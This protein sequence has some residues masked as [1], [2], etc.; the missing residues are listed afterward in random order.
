L[1][2]KE[3]PYLVIGD[4]EVPPGATVVIEPGTIF[5]FKNFTTLHIHGTLLS[6]G[7]K[8]Q[9]IVFSSENDTAYN[10]HSSLTP[11]AYDWNGITV[12]DNSNGT[13]FRHCNIK[14]SLYGIN[15]LTKSI[16]VETCSFIQIGKV[17]LT[18]EGSKYENLTSDFVFNASVPDTSTKPLL[19][20]TQKSEPAPA[21]KPVVPAA[22]PR[23]SNLRFV[24]RYSG[25]S[26]FGAG[27]A[28]FIWQTQKYFNAAAEFDRLN[29][30]GNPANTM[31]PN[32]DKD[33]QAAKN[34]KNNSLA[35]MI[36][37]GAVALLGAAGFGISFLF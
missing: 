30:T 28:L 23:K 1:K 34:R 5:L 17:D 7:T 11:A 35:Y 15:S 8:E 32:I 31:N 25:I 29:D 6:R 37:G 19:A 33:W 13:S 22:P 36:T 9:P 2:K 4:I 18:I 12:Y 26:L 14:Y 21:V 20:V 27:A 3:R 24:L 16:S 10:R